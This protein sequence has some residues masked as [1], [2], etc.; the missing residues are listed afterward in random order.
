R[1]KR[2]NACAGAGSICLERGERS[3]LHRSQHLDVAVFARAR[4]ARVG[5]DLDLSFAREIAEEPARLAEIEAKARGDGLERE[6]RVG[7]RI[8]GDE[9]TRGVA[10]ERAK[11]F[12]NRRGDRLL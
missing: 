12:G 3:S 8:T 11:R 7:A 5:A 2:A 6:G 9:R 4:G 10:F 1:R